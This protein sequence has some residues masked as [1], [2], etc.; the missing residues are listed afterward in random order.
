[1]KKIYLLFLIFVNISFSQEY[2]LLDKQ[3][4][5]V[6]YAHLF[7]DDVF[8]A[9][10]DEKGKFNIPQKPFEKLEIQHISFQTKTLKRIELPENKQ[11]VLEENTFVLSEVE[12]SSPKKRKRKTLLPEKSLLNTI[13]E[14]ADIQLIYTHGSNRIEYSFLPTVYESKAVY[15]PNEKPNKKAFI[16]KIILES[17]DKQIEGDT[18]YIPFRVN[19]MSYD[20][21]AN[22]PNEKIRT[23]DWVVGKRV[24]ERVEIEVDKSVIL[25]FPKEGICVMVSVYVPEFYINKRMTPPRFETVSIIKSSLFR[26]YK[27]THRRDLQFWE[28]MPYSKIREQCFNFGIEVEYQD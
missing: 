24:G 18:L 19:L 6:S 10:S 5:A 15:I 12:V 21:I 22:L 17:R 25:E 26:E 7:L 23:E 11:I 13:M 9:Y 8:F 2:T 4:I 3:G 20:T 1:M 28:E 16:K 14:K 27:L